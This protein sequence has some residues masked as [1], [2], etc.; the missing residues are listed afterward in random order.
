MLAGY[1]V[2]DRTERTG[3]F[4][5]DIIRAERAELE[6]QSC[7]LTL[8]P[9]CRL[10]FSTPEQEGHEDTKNMKG[11]VCGESSVR[12]GQDQLQWQ[13]QPRISRMNADK[14][15]SLDWHLGAAIRA[16]R[17]LKGSC[18]CPRS[19]ALVRVRPRLLLQLALPFALFFMLFASSCSSRSGFQDA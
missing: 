18:R 3:A 2:R 11:S 17:S 1:A 4:V 15:K 16:P 14:S 9:A 10:A 8:D 7:A 13:Q 5:G 12:R 6:S 19:S